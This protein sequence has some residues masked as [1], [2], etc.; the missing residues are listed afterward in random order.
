M[1]HAVS[2]VG[3]DYFAQAALQQHTDTSNQAALQLEIAKGLGSA[4]LFAE[5]VILKLG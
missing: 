1:Q 3:T 5:Q 4:K 2:V